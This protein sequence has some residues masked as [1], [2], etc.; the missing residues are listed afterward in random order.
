MPQPWRSPPK[1]NDTK[2]TGSRDT[3]RELWTMLYLSFDGAESVNDD[4]RARM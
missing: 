2:P 4:D 1:Q 3:P